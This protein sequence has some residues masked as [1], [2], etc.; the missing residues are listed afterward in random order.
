MNTVDY[1]QNWSLPENAMSWNG[2]WL[3]EEIPG[4]R[5]LQVS[6]EEKTALA[7]S[8]ISSAV[9]NGEE[10]L[11]RKLQPRSIEV[12]FALVSASASGLRAALNRLRGILSS[13]AADG[14]LDYDAESTV[15]FADEADKYYKGVMQDFSFEAPA[16][17][18]GTGSFTIYC[19]D[20]LKYAVDP[21]TVEAVDGLITLEYGG[22]F[23]A[24]P[25]LAAEM[26]SNASYIGF[27]DDEEHIIQIGDP[28]EASSSRSLSTLVFS[29]SFASG[30][31]AG[32]AANAALCTDPPDGRI[33]IHTGAV[34]TV[35]EY[36]RTGIG[37]HMESADYGEGSEWH[38]PTLTRPVTASK[39]CTAS[40]DHWLQYAAS[41]R[42]G[43]FAVC[44][45]GTLNGTRTNIAAVWYTKDAYGTNRGRIELTVLGEVLHTIEFPLTIDNIY[46]GLK[47]G[48]IENY[49]SAAGRVYTQP[50]SAAGMSSIRKI[51]SVIT[52][53]IAG[54]VKEFKIPDAAA[55]A[56][57]EVSVLF[58]K[59]YQTPDIGG[60]VL[61]SMQFLK[62]ADSAQS[63]D[64]IMT[65][66]AVGD[67]VKADCR[68]GSIKINGVEQYGAGALGNDWEEM[69]LKPGGNEI[70]CAYSNWAQSP[71]FSLTYR[72]AYL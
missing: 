3:E 68:S 57:T 65:Y 43:M 11:R 56:V 70:R 15:I 10:Y 2:L 61:Y 69:S 29:D 13:T 60:N 58:E 55:A 33:L 36:G 46:T 14:R 63:V 30:V 38:G 17:Y 45:D 47:Q 18:A 37:S 7:I 41:S 9:R 4:Y 8:T 67:V 19:A 22:T 50:N 5:T 42:L 35:Q 1:M 53:N 24:Y 34:A 39:N 26:T 6:R 12:E 72:E 64:D 16:K 54:T 31:P 48:Q 71:A 32:W 44:L 21:T 23:P 66:L 51:G 49:P 52:F 20:P 27:V 25:E 59:W 40:W 62:H 28:D